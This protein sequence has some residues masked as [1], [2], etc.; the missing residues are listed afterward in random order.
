MADKE[1]TNFP[2]TESEC[3]AFMCGDHN[4]R[5]EICLCNE[6]NAPLL[7]AAPNV[8]KDSFVS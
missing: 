5:S 2:F 8:D 7:K 6:K 1:F 3:F 4:S